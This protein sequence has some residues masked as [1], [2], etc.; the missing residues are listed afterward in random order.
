M[1]KVSGRIGCRKMRLNESYDGPIISK[2]TA[3]GADNYMLIYEIRDSIKQKSYWC[4]LEVLDVELTEIPE[5]IDD[6]DWIKVS[7]EV[8]AKPKKKAKKKRQI[9]Q[10]HH[11]CYSPE[12]L[13]RVR[14]KEHYWITRLQWFKEISPGAVRA[15]IWELEHKP[16]IYERK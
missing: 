7:K 14:R 10:S 8:I 4:P 13:V 6:N 2:M 3:I 1:I 9:W 12:L 5:E 15:I 16:R 11:L